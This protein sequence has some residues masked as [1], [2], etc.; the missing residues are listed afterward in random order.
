MDGNRDGDRNWDRNRNEDRDRV[1][2]TW[3]VSTPGLG[4]GLRRQKA[5]CRSWNRQAVTLS[6][7]MDV[8]S[9]A[10]PIP[11]VGERAHGV[12]S[13]VQGSMHEQRMQ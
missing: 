12:G 13:R 4:Q 7:G 5:A 9:S 11:G 1:L 6:H 10:L 3:Q 8:A 2:G